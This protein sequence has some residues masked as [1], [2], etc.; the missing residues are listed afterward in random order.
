MKIDDEIERECVCVCT[1]MQAYVRQGVVEQER[2]L[3]GYFIV[4]LKLLY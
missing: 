2:Q 3:C 1:H 4:F